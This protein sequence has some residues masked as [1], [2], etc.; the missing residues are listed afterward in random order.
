MDRIHFHLVRNSFSEGTNWKVKGNLIALDMRSNF[1]YEEA[2]LIIEK[3]TLEN[4]IG[5]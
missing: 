4:L 5:C 3:A 2:I 1:K